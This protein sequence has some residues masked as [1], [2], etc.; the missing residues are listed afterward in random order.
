MK[1]L[2]ERQFGFDPALLGFPSTSACRA[3]VFQTLNGL[4]GYHN[5][6]MVM[7]GQLQPTIDALIA[8]DVAQKMK[9]DPVSA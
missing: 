3:I 8:H 5:L 6:G 4:F 9:G 7:E 2:A 1:H